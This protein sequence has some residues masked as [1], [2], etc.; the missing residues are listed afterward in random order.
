MKHLFTL[1]HSPT[2]FLNDDRWG[3]ESKTMEDSHL[4][5]CGKGHADGVFFDLVIQLSLITRGISYVNI[6]EEEAK[7]A[8]KEVSIQ[9]A[10]LK[11]G[12]IGIQLLEDS[13]DDDSASRKS[14]EKFAQQNQLE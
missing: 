1:L 3:D 7:P 5:R 6:Q 14:T 12:K 11:N 10:A 2:C 13:S 8:H 4:S 9:A